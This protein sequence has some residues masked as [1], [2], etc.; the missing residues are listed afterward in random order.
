QSL[1][2]LRDIGGSEIIALGLAY[3]IAT[4]LGAIVLLG[5]FEYRFGDFIR[6]ISRAWWQSVVA[7]L[8]AMAA[9]YAILAIAGPL[10]VGSTTL[11]VF[12]KGLAGG[13]TGLIVAGIAY[14]MLGSQELEETIL[15]VY[16]RYI[17]QTIERAQGVAV[18]TSAEE[19]P[20]QS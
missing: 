20:G 11:S 9:T 18:A 5:F 13:L 6:R 3:A 17:K 15:A 14:W 1:M 2:R 7:S 8:A 19:Q 4:I 12:L 16:G 10:D